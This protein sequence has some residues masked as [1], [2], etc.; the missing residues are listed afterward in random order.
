M[1]GE[2]TAPPGADGPV[3]KWMALEGGILYGLVGEKEFFDPGHQK[4]DSPPGWPWKGMSP[5]YDLTVYPWGFGRTFFA[6][7]PQ[8]KRVRWVHQETEKIDSRGVC[9]KAGRIYCYSE[10]KFL[11]CLDAASG[12]P[13]WRAADEPLLRAIGPTGRAQ[14]WNTGMST[15]IYLMCSD[16]AV[17]FLGPQRPRLVA[18]SAADGRLLWQYPVGN[19]RGV[20]RERRALRAGR[21]SRQRRQPAARSAQRPDAG[22]I[23]LPP[24]QLHAGTGTADGIFCRAE[25]EW[26]TGVLRTADQQ[27]RRLPSMRP[28]CHDGVIDDRGP[29]TL[30]HLDLRLQCLDD[31]KH[32]AWPRPATSIF[33]SRPRKPIAWK[34]RRIGAAGVAAGQTSRCGRCLRLIP[35]RAPTGRSDWP[36]FRADNV[37]SAAVPLPIGPKAALAWTYTPPAAVDPAAPIVADETV[38]SSG[39]DG[40]IRAL[41]TSNGELKWS[42]YTGG[43]ILFP[44]VAYRKRL[45]AGSGDGWVYCF[46]ADSG[47]PCWRFRAAP[48]ERKIPVYGKLCSTWPVGSG[49]LADQGVVYAAA[50]M[51]SY[52]GTHVYALDAETGKYPL[53]EQHFR[54]PGRCRQ[55]S[56]RKRARALAAARREALSGR[57]QRRFSG[58]VRH[59]RRPLPE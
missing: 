54:P 11:A 23:G 5:G 45:Y 3:W 34:R 27:F 20:L 18:V 42:A 31:R 43:P 41:A 53:A 16:Q 22:H 52:D 46:D 48:V 8:T 2:I 39:A 12:K 4:A 35:L 21:A 50:G 55:P 33:N 51:A 25:N 49:V 1:E 32:H 13:L 36:T 10:Q 15:F 9:M 37:R 14:S 58:R 47:R 40:V 56:R 30:G 6:V 59:A 7:D 57:R 29:G 26:G 38:F 28:P 19:F 24:R 44:P 17:Y